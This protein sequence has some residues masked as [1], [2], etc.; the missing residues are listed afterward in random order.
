[1]NK[2]LSAPECKNVIEDGI[3]S[4]DFRTLAQS[5]SDLS[6]FRSWGRTFQSL[7]SWSKSDPDCIFFTTFLAGVPFFQPELKPGDPGGKSLPGPYT[8]EL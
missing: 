2:F 7:K 4:Q 6:Y 5:W 8:M 1:V 3:K